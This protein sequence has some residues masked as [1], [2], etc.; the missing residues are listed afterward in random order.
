MSFA[1]AAERSGVNI[2]RR[3]SYGMAISEYTIECGF[4]D[5]TSSS[6]PQN[7]AAPFGAPGISGSSDRFGSLFEVGSNFNIMSLG[8]LENA[9][10]GEL[11]I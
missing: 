10:G 1:A 2:L 4:Q 3:P 5:Q 6:F 11:R 8:L 9:F 7:H